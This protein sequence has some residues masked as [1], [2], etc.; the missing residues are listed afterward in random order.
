VELQKVEHSVVGEVC[1]VNGVWLMTH[2]LPNDNFR[3]GQIE[4]CSSVT[5]RAM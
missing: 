4:M 1:D 5:W 2:M 3:S